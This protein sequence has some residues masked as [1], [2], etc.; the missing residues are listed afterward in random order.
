MNRLIFV[1]SFFAF[2]FLLYE[3]ASAYSNPGPPT[4][5]VNDYATIFTPDQRQDLESK[6]TDFEKQTTN[7]ISVVTI[8]SLNGDTIEDFASKLFEEWNIGKKG[9][10]NGVLLLVAVDDREVRIE[11]GYG[12]E[13]VLTDASSYWIIQNQIIPEFK[14]DNYF[15]GISAGTDIIIQT[16][17]GEFT[18]PTAE[19]DQFD[20]QSILPIIF[21]IFAGLSWIA[22][23]LARTKSWWAGGVLGGVAGLIITLVFGFITIGAI[24]LLILV[25]LGL[26]FD[27]LI[28]KSYREHTQN[29][30]SIPWWAGGNN[31]F[32]SGGSRGFGGFGGGRS[33][34]GGAS[35]RW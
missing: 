6:L 19:L 12:L 11:V 13:G 31:G 23:I 3:V 21:F 9:N 26:L 18:P 29:S 14:S 27:Y 34:G 33:G 30:S 16:I 24:S 7:E 22:S 4:G 25:P 15:Q 17:S 32:S 5:F 10:D 20:P 8:Q 35:G 28:S 2:S 1:I